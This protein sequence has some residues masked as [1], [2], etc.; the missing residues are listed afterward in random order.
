M[1]IMERMKYVIKIF[2]VGVGYKNKFNFKFTYLAFYNVYL[3]NI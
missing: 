1:V 2:V 3:C